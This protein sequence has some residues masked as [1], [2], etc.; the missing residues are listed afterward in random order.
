[1]KWKEVSCNVD[2]PICFQQ[3]KKQK[4]DDIDIDVWVFKEQ[5]GPKIIFD[6]L[7]KKQ[8]TLKED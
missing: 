8:K 7:S 4:H 1:M 3:L 2:W 6:Y 5:G